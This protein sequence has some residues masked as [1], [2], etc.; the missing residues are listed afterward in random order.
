[1]QIARTSAQARQEQMGLHRM[2]VVEVRLCEAY[3]SQL[4]CC[5]GHAQ[6]GSAR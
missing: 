5:A 3:Y 1:M 2:G 6:A 4:V